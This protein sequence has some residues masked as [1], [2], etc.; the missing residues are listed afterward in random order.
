[1]S[2]PQ[3]IEEPRTWVRPSSLT[4]PTDR[5]EGTKF[6]A[7]RVP[8]L[9]DTQVDSAIQARLIQCLVDF[10]DIERSYLDP[11][12]DGQEVAVFSFVP[13]KGATPDKNGFY[14]FGKVRGSFSDA[15][16]ASERA[17]H[18]LRNVDSY[19]DYQ[20]C[21]VGYPFPITKDPRYS[22]RMQKVHVKSAIKQATSAQIAEKREQE[23]REVQELREREQKIAE[24]SKE[25]VYNPD[26]E[27]NY[28][29]LRVKNAQLTF[30]F[31]K[32]LDA[33]REQRDI[34]NRTRTNMASVEV[35][36]PEFRDRYLERYLK[37]RDDVGL[38]S[39]GENASFMRYMH[40]FEDLPTSI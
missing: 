34:I 7:V 30:T 24:E 32:Q 33:L 38:A 15:R 25:E 4:T 29:M 39:D 5:A 23:K 35:T 14:G 12:V 31:F 6:E 9:T 18:L 10:P 17:E 19:H 27:E 8:P 20:L 13:A 11:A 21:N 22:K 37:A 1:M 2:S 28:T 40:T 26:P 36:N 3:E 16:R